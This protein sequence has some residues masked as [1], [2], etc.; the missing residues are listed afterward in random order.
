MNRLYPNMQVKKIKDIDLDYLWQLGIRGLVFDLDNTIT[1]F[2]L[3]DPDQETAAWFEMLKNRG[4]AVCI[5]SNSMQKKVETLS[6]WL[7]IPI[8]GNSKKPSRAGFKRASQTL[9]LPPKQLAMIGDQLFTDI[10]G[11]N[12]AGFFTILTEKIGEAE[13][14]GTKNISRRAEKIVRCLWPKS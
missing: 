4:F 6:E 11:G 14:W 5:L 1:P 13:F 10:Y 9:E 7:N 3:Y 2:Q 8:L 12:K